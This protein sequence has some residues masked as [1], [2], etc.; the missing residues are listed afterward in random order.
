MSDAPLPSVTVLVPVRDGIDLL[1]LCLAAIA[2]QDY[3]AHLVQTVVVD[4]NSTQDIAAVVAHHA[5]V[6][7]LREST[8]GSYAARNAGIDV[9]TGDVLAFTDA[10]C[11]PAPG[12]LCAAVA[13]LVDATG[14]EEVPTMVGGAVELVYP[15][16]RPVSAGEL[17]EAVHGFRQERYVTELHFAA[18]ANMVTWRRSMDQVGRFDQELSGGDAQWGNRLADAGGVQRWAP[19]A[20]VRHPARSSLLELARKCH[21]TAKGHVRIE[22]ARGMTR[23]K[24]MHVV[25]W[26]I[27]S[28]RREVGSAR[29]RP[30][31]PTAAARA[32]YLLAYGVFCGANALAF[33]R[34]ALRVPAPRSAAAA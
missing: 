19:D 25:H 9:A 11:R 14:D 13:A 23:N 2:A 12:W 31:L 17:Y 15:R 33:T 32:R 22:R 1:D 4:N 30:E 24:A 28:F 6:V 3:P 26:Q 18:T 34:A 27:I 20:V 16:G 8:P 10:D 21:R 5:G 29:E 7:L